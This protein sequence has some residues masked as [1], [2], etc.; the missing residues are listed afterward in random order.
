MAHPDGDRV[1]AFYSGGGDHRGRT[2]ALIREWTDDR[3]EATHDYI[4]WMFPTAT[5]SGVNTFAPLVTAGTRQAFVDRPELRDELRR[6]L[7]RMLRFYG[8]RRSTS[9]AG[10]VRISI[11]EAR[12]GDRA[13][14]WLHPGNHNHLRL[15][16][17]VQSLALLGL[18]PEAL[19]LRACLLSDIADG[20]GRTRITPE[21]LRYW[22]GGLET[23]EHV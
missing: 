4:Q 2:L 22:R 6:S 7:D 1:V 17:I 3:L 10:D 13:A 8:L 5:P 19:A 23:A 12:F 20:P 9:A 16:R 11:D 14:A 18:R 15:T 21:T